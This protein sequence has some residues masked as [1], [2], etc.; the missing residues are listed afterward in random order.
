MQPQHKK[1]SLLPHTAIGRSGLLFILLLFLA[2]GTGF[3]QSITIEDVS[4]AENGGAITLTATLN[5]GTSGTPF[6]V[7]VNTNDGTATVADSDYTSITS[8]TLFFDGNDGDTQT[9]DVV[10]TADNSVEGDETLTITMDNLDGVG[11]VNIDDEATVTI[12]NDDFG[13]VTISATDASA[14]ET[15]PDT[16]VFEID[17]GSVNATG[18]DIT[19]NYIVN[20]ASTA[21][22]GDDFDA[23]P[24]SLSIPDGSQ[25]GTIAITPIDDTVVEE[26][27]FVRLELTGT[28]DGTLFPI[29]TPNTA[30][31]TIDSDD[32]ATVSI[33]NDTDG[34]ENNGGGPVTNGI[35][36]ISQSEESPVD[37]DITYAISGGTATEGDDFTALSGTVTIFAGDTS[38]EITIPV[39]E[40]AIV[41]GDETIEITLTGI[42]S[43]LAESDVPANIVAINTILDDD[44]ATLTIT[45]VSVSE[46]VAGGNMVFAVTLDNE[47]SGGTDVTYTFTDDTATG[48]GTDYDSTG[49]ILNFTG[50]A[51]EVQEITV[52]ITDD[53]VVEGAET[54]EVV[55][56]TPT[57]GVGVSGSP[58]TGTITDDDS[59]T[60]TITDVSVSEDVASGNMVFT[61]TL[62]N[63]VSGGTDVTYT[64]NDDTATGGGTD[65]DSTGGT[66]NFTGTASE[67]QEITVAITDDEVVEGAET[68]EVDLG[69][70]IN[71]VGV[72]G[73]PATGT[74]T[75]D[76]TASIV[77]TPTGV[78]IA[79]SEDGTTD[80]FT[81]ELGAQPVNDVVLNISSSDTSEGDVST[82]QI[83]FT[84]A[85]WDD[86]QGII[87]TGIDDD[88]IDGDIDYDI[89]V[90]VVDALSDDQFDALSDVIISTQNTDNDTAGITVVE[91]DGN[92]VTTEDSDTDT[93]D[94]VLDAE[95]ATDVVVDIASDDTGE[96]TVSPASL[97]FTPGNWD[98]PQEVTVTGVDDAIID[99][100]ENYDITISVNNGSSDN[101]FDGISEIVS[102]SNTDNDSASFTI[103]ETDGSTNTS[104]DGTTDTF[105]VVLDIQ[106]N[107]NVVFDVVSEDDTE[108]EVSPPTLTFT[109][110]N[111]NIPQTVTVEGQNDNVIDDSQTYNINVSVI[112]A[113]SDNAFNNLSDVVEVTNSDD[114]TAGFTI[115]ESD[116]ETSVSETGTTDTF[117]VVL[118]RGTVFSNVIIDIDSEDTGE[119]TVSPSSLTF[120]PGNWNVPQIVTVT[121][122]DDAIVDGTV[123]FD[124]TVSVNPF[125]AFSY[126]ILPDQTVEV[127]NI[128]DDSASVTISNASGNEDDGP[129]TVSATLNN[130]VTGGFTVDV[131]S[132]DGIATTAS[133]D[134]TAVNETLTFAG[135]AGEVQTFELVPIADALV[136]VDETV[137]VAMVNLDDPSLPVSIS[138]TATITINNDDACAAGTA[139]PTLNDANNEFCVEVFSDFSQELDDYVDGTPPAGSQLV[140]S[141]NPDTAQTDDY[142]GSSVI[143]GSQ[144][145]NQNTYY[146]FY[147]DSLN[148]CA[149][150]NTVQVVL[151]VN[152]E[153]NPGTTT[154]ASICADSENGSTIL[155]L[156]DRLSADADPG[157]WSITEAQPGA[158]ITISGDNMVNFDGQPFG[159]YTFT[160]TA[161]A[162]GIC[163]DQTV[164]LV[165]TVSDCAGPCNAG[166]TAPA[167]NGDD[168]TIEFC[169]EVNT[170]LDSYVSG[171]AP[172]GTTLIWS[173][174]SE[175]T[176][177]GAHLNS[178]QVVEPGTYYGFYYDEANDCGSPVL[179]ITLV[180]NFTPTIDTTTGDSSCGPGSLTL[181]ANAS[182]ADDSAIS[183]RWYDAPTGGSIVSTS[184]TY[185]TGDLTETTS[186]YVT[187]TANG[188]ESERVQVVA[189]IVNALSAGMPIEGLTACNVSSDEGPTS[190]DLDDGLM[191]QDAGTWVVLTDPSNG[192]LTI[193]TDNIVDFTGLSSGEYVF[194]YTTEPV[195]DCTETSS[196]QLTIT[197]QDCVTNETIDLGVVKT[198]DGGNSYLI[199]DEVT[200][201]INVENAEGSTVTDI[202]ISEIL[203]E[204]FEFLSAEATI[205]AY[206]D[207]TG[208]W[209]IPLLEATDTEATLTIRVRTTAAGQIS[210]TASLVSSV[211][212][213]DNPE[214]N[215]S[216]VQVEVNRN[217]C[218]TPGTICNIFSPNG[219]GVNDT[220]KL[221]GSDGLY[222]QASLEVYDRYG[223][224][225]FQMDG[226]DSSWDGTGKNGDLPKGT[227]FYVLDLNGDGTD[228]VKGWIQIVRNN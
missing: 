22:S 202:V 10:P 164:E 168:T 93:F 186:F 30:D 175:P 192:D 210:N 28:S 59:A 180:R 87:V 132:S 53:A 125:S 49:G 72:S 119:G 200:F 92:T 223:N 34:A 78:D 196:A 178:G 64:F 206:D 187:A 36:T 43:G 220:L 61:V 77:I 86:P 165:V 56:G 111:W 27:E 38:A 153:P 138:D 177:T 120:T 163:A 81:V 213:D 21:V 155:D 172:S 122:I 221:V 95:P 75:D 159:D 106:P 98:T 99:G 171:T 15:G 24:L 105:T 88:I 203:D 82:G 194:E 29:G 68:F 118:N 12:L 73:S 42:A 1:T 26:Q 74:I 225:V 101:E 205:G 227:Y 46:D 11:G 76:D 173:T 84:N 55:L 212:A 70:P 114:D 18:S 181:T 126:A 39:L 117:T 149:S 130:E 208:E 139:T 110:S 19:I 214:N 57:N 80:T 6:S 188:C 3:G 16:G 207:N 31:V 107:S 135:T 62:D 85:N 219:D 129:I 140:W 112:N 90:S 179:P 113:S 141:S 148:D 156:D 41:E 8:Q 198:V 4:G 48:G 145:V 100:D 146:G 128:D 226:Y 218:E 228:V 65:Y 127:E 184:A 217:Q 67:V 124:V 131:L 224:S 17:L 66:L 47:V 144:V 162:S 157:V 158:S 5:V 174:S 204:D 211:P 14:S 166:D 35:L 2:I 123:N 167:F 51:S 104:E 60:L 20:G 108:G 94:V 9:F 25:T 134:Y 33:A 190:F 79:T 71:G 44:S 97:T 116:G 63:A 23:L 183:Y 91:T 115:A 121:G 189:A 193:G 96:G 154:G 40:D 143:T 176:E 83:T 182:V 50:T 102:V 170:D 52:A 89:T 152:E 151:S 199:G 195:G 147:Y 136:E 13:E 185:T 37:T 201:I 215:T 54:F 69:T 169:D 109:T 103:V 150:P 191:G 137:E 160:Y 222:T 197:V 58:A 209:T 45:D 133:S 7:D 142:L 216:T 161:T 32:L